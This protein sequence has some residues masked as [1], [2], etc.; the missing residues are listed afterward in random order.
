[1]YSLRDRHKAVYHRRLPGM[2]GNA[3]GKRY[4]FSPTSSPPV[5]QS[6]RLENNKI[7]RALSSLQGYSGTRDIPREGA[8]GSGP[9]LLSSPWSL[10]G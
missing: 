4:C 1:M 10:I 8:L 6:G 7:A 5:K 3:E 9:E 2:Q